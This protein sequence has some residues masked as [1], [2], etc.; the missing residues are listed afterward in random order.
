MEDNADLKSVALATQLLDTLQPGTRNS[1]AKVLNL[2]RRGIW[3]G[4]FEAATPKLC[5]LWSFGLGWE[6]TQ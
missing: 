3:I 1:R 5:V 2:G 4:K 6:R